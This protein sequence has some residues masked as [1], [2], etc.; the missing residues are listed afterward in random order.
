MQANFVV[1]SNLDAL[2][3]KLGALYVRFKNGGCYKY[4]GVPFPVFEALLNA[5]SVGQYLNK[6][7]KGV[8]DYVKLAADPFGS[9]K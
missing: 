4:V 7:V 3:Y 9:Q 8:Y 1:S 5:E 6:H 2:G